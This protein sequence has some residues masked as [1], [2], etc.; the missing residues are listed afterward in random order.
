MLHKAGRTVEIADLI[1]VRDD[2]LD[3]NSKQLL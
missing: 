2:H 1:K 3:A